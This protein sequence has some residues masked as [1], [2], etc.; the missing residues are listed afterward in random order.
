MEQVLRPKEG[1]M[2]KLLL[3]GV[4]ALAAVAL[5]VTVATANNGNGHRKNGLHAKL[6]GYQQVPTLSSPGQ[7]KFKAKVRGDVV[8]YKL[9][10]SGLPT[11]VTVAHIHL[12]RPATTGGPIAFLCGGSKPA[13]PPSGE[14]TGTIVP[15]D[16]IGP[17]AQGIDPG[18]FDE[19]VAALR[20]KATYVN[21]HTTQYTDGE[22]RGQVGGFGK[23]HDFGFGHEG[24]KEHGREGGKGHDRD[25]D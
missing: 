7:G 18:E 13:C 20:A 4:L 25:D 15:A 22:I 10:Y 17:A 11:A 2:K 1:Q 5:V 24:G 14:V 16:V 19:F 23:F 12:G 3:A 6:D 21:V 9:Q 8:E